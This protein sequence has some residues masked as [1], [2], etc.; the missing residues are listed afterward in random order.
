M[1]EPNKAGCCGESDGELRPLGAKEILE[2]MLASLQT[3]KAAGFP[4]ASDDVYHRRL[5]VC[6][7]CPQ[8]RWFQ[9]RHC[10]CIVYSKAKLATE[11]CPLKLWS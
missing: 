5:R 1:S 9:C 6:R 8:Y 2:H 7:R 3:W 10:R 4:L 11:D